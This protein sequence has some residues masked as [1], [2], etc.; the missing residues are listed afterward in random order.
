MGP[1]EA[2]KDYL[3]YIPLLEGIHESNRLVKNETGKL[4][5]LTIEFIIGSHDT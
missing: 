2:Q 4:D 5:Q 1:H 3:C